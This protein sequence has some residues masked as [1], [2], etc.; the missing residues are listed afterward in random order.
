MEILKR[1]FR[2]AV[3]IGIPVAVQYFAASTNP[4]FLLAA[5]LLTGIGKWLRDKYAVPFVPV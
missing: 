5:P 3:S 2:A 4:L 1:V